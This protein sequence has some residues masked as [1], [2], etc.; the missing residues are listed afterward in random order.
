MILP[1]NHIVVVSDYLP[2]TALVLSRKSLPK[3]VPGKRVL[4]AF[5]R[6]SILTPFPP[7]KLM[8]N[9]Y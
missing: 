7:L 9:G 2:M 6:F 5:G 1:P 3:P 8:K 4:F